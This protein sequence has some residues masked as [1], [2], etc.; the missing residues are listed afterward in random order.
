MCVLKDNTVSRKEMYNFF[1][2][3]AFDIQKK[4]RLTDNMNKY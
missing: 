4:K 3:P 2:N 1:F